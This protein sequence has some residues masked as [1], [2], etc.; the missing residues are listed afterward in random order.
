MESNGYGSKIKPK[1]TVKYKA[2]KQK[3][4][5]I[6]ADRMYRTTLMYYLE[7]DCMPAG[8]ELE[9]ITHIVYNK[10]QGYHVAFDEIQCLYLARQEKYK[11][12]IHK[13][14]E[15]GVTLESLQK[16]PKVKKACKTPRPKKKSKN[17]KTEAEPMQDN[18]FF[19]IAGYTSGG[20]PYGVTWDEM[21][22]EPWQSLSD[23]EPDD[24]E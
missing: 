12:R 10:I 11:A 1:P 8:E 18:R 22:L 6:I 2:L 17:G 5:A 14:I 15:C 9:K 7:Y 16:P 4:K 23:S 21:G 3:Q 13:D 24:K 19:F 20:A